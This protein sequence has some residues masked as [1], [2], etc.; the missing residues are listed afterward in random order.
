[1]LDNLHIRVFVAKWTKISPAFWKL[2]KEWLVSSEGMQVSTANTYPVNTNK[3]FS[4]SKSWYNYIFEFK[5][6]WLFTNLSA[7][8]NSQIVHRFP[9]VHKRHATSHITSSGAVVKIR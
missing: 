4:R 3:S 7:F 6:V 5:L 2:K 8:C 9:R 1:M